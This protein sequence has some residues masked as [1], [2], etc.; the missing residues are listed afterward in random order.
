M[1]CYGIFWS[2]QL[3]PFATR[4]KVA[5]CT[6]FYVFYLQLYLGDLYD[7]YML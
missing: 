2:G 7:I 5:F 1:V 3:P 4:M 6:F